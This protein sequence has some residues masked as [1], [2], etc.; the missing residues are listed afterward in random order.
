MSEIIDV[1]HTFVEETG[2]PGASAAVFSADGTISSAAVGVRAVDAPQEPM[3]T[4]TAGPLYSLSK[5]LTMTGIAILVDQGELSFDEPITR[6]LPDT[7]QTERFSTTTLRHL[8]SHTSGLL[9]VA[10]SPTHPAQSYDALERWA[11]G[12]GLTTGRLSLPEQGVFGYSKRGRRTSRLCRPEGRPGAVRVCDAGSS[13][14]PGQDAAG[15]IRPAGRDDRADHPA[16]HAGQGATVGTAPVRSARGVHAVHRC[17]RVGDGPGQAGHGAAR[18]GQRASL[19]VRASSAGYS[20]PHSGR[21]TRHRANTRA[22]GG[23]MAAIWRHGVHRA[24]RSLVGLL[25]QTGDYSGAANWCGLAGQP[26]RDFDRGLRGIRTSSIDQLLHLA[27]AGS[28]DAARAYVP[29]DLPSVAVASG[30]YARPAGRPIEIT[31]ENDAL[32]A[33][34]GPRTARYSH[35]SGRVFVADESKDL[36]GYV[37]WEPEIHTDRSALCLVGPPKSPTHLLLNGVPYRRV[38]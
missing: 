7:E 5:L 17:F 34:D 3:T 4:D 38:R 33:T 10:P 29:N 36:M 18:Y 11:L 12:A 15:H 24:R 2:I 35:L 1:L 9:P 22:R 16:A 30:T 13:V 25:A 20:P 27:G 23:A 28:R 19:A 37:P 21:R 26:R 32:V 8:L 31:A 14:R 6:Y